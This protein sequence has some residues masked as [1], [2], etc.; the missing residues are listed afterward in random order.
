VGSNPVSER[1]W[2][3]PL[4][5]TRAE[6][7]EIKNTDQRHPRSRVAGTVRCERRRGT[8]GDRLHGADNGGSYDRTDANPR[9]AAMEHGSTSVAD[10]AAMVRRHEL[11]DVR[12]ALVRADDS[13]RVWHGDVTLG[14]PRPVP[15]RTWRYSHV[16][17]MEHRLDAA[18]VAELLREPQQQ[19]ADLAVSVPQM[20]GNGSFRRMAGQTEYLYVTMP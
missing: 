13:W 4:H 11:A 14:S 10:I 6:G 9:K 15:G 16:M 7:Q 17:L 12:I 3:N 1:S 8:G 20:S 2:R 18:I 19:L 5:L